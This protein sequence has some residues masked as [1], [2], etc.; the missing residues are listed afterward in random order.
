MDCRVCGVGLNDENLYP[1]QKKQYNWICMGCFKKYQLEK[2]ERKIKSRIDEKIQSEI[3]DKY[4]NGVSSCELSEEY[5]ISVPRICNI[6]HTRDIKIRT[7]QESW[8]YEKHFTD[9]CVEKIRQNT[10]KRHND[11]GGK[12]F[13]PKEYIPWNKNTEGICKSNSGSFKKGDIPPNKIGDGISR[14][15]KLIRGM[16]EYKEWRNH[17]F[18]R[19]LY[20]CKHC[21]IRGVYFE[22][23]HIK[24]LWRIIKEYNMK[25]I[26]D[27]RNCKELWDLNN[28]ITLCKECH[29][30]I[31]MSRSD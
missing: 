25:T 12:G 27:A 22:A 18:G 28:G 29:G 3:C 11:S 19:D 23:H 9:E 16:P 24:E 13:F 10:I 21:N 15:N 5:N 30:K 17:I 20:T 2:K 8:K 7:P 4:I 26:I 1:S 14:L 6:L 31:D